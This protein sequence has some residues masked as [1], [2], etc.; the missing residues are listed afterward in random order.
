MSVL[1][2]LWGCKSA[3]APTNDELLC[4]SD[5]AEAIQTDTRYAVLDVRQPNEYADGHIEGATNLN[6]LDSLTFKKRLKTLDKTKTYY[7]YCRSGGRSRTA[8]NILRCN[9]FKV[10]E[11]QGGIGAWI[12][13]GLPIVK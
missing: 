7:V 2:F 8:T 10:K 3:S 12:S 13:A 9:G 4:A 6:V 1:S 5:F 11:L